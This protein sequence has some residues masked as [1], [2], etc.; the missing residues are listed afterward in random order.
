MGREHI[1]FAGLRV[2]YNPPPYAHLL[3]SQIDPHD[4]PRLLG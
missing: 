3:L 2:R 1:E 4:Q